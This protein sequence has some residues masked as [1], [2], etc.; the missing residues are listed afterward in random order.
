MQTAEP[1]PPCSLGLC[2]HRLCLATGEIKYNR[3]AV[4][5]AKAIFSGFISWDNTVTGFDGGL[6]LARKASVDLK[7][8]LV[9]EEGR[10]DAATGFV[11][12]QLVQTAAE[13]IDRSW[14]ILSREIAS[15]RLIMSRASRLTVSY[16]PLDFGMGLW[17]LQFF[18]SEDWVRALANE[19]IMLAHRALIDPPGI[20]HMPLDRR[21]AFR[22]F[23][24]CLGLQCYGAGMELTAPELIR[25]WQ[26]SGY[27]EAGVHGGLNLVMY[28]TAHVPGAF[29]DGYIWRWHS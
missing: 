15:Y 24:A 17:M 9:P 12:L 19:S 23:G 20:N 3:L 4:Q 1:S 28:A 26:T 7:V 13:R 16:D 6:R 21:V 8:I 10:Y 27:F 25:F 18:R 5:L 29:R 22:E 14:G 2:P 11:V